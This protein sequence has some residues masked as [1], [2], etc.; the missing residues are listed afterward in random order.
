MTVIEIL[1]K[2]VKDGERTRENAIAWLVK[3]AEMPLCK[4]KEFI[5]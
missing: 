2:A 4:A 1:N 3:Y 5:K